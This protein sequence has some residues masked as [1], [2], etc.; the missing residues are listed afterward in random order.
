MKKKIDVNFPFA[1]ATGYVADS[2][3]KSLTVYGL[4]T[5]VYQKVACLRYITSN[6]RGQGDGNRALEAFIAKC[7]KAGAEAIVLCYD[8]SEKQSKGFVLKEWY[9]KYGFDQIGK[10][11]FMV[12]KLK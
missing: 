4:D 5:S 2:N 6:R 3:D 1:E 10:T 8:L 9:E 12:K 11:F 7:R